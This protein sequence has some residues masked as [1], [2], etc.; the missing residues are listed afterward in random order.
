MLPARNIRGPDRLSVSAV[1]TLTA[2]QRKMQTIDSTCFVCSPGVNRSAFA[3]QSFFACASDDLFGL[4][5]RDFE[6]S[7]V[8]GGF[9]EELFSFVIA[10]FGK[11]GEGCRQVV[12][13][14]V[15]MR[16]SGIS[17]KSF[18]PWKA[19]FLSRNRAPVAQSSTAPAS[20]NSFNP[21][22][23]PLRAR[24]RRQEEG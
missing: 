13:D 8:F 16:F 24:S 22:P 12:L 20:Y 7:L 21:S 15:V 19:P 6:A 2:T 3:P 5:R 11:F 4:I 14:I 17:V 10:H 18:G 23:P 1:A 9:V